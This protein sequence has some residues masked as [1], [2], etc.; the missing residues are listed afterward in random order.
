MATLLGEDGRRLSAGERQMIGLI[1]VLLTQP[2]VLIID[3]GLNAL[4]PQSYRMAV[5]ALSARASRRATLLISH[6]QSVLDL[7]DEQFRLEGGVI[8]AWTDCEPEPEAE[9]A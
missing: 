5:Q 6:H 9:A 8:R 3:E 1:R 2:E 7:A 4:D